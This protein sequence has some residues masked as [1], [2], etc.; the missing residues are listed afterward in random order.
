MTDTNWKDKM[1]TEQEL[2]E[3]IDECQRQLKWM[4]KEP[5][6]VETEFGEFEIEPETGTISVEGL[7][8][9]CMATLFGKREH[10]RVTFPDESMMR[11][12]FPDA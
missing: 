2:N 6:K 3:A 11:E 7:T 4:P 8:W 12:V 9:S 1:P 5:I 10:V